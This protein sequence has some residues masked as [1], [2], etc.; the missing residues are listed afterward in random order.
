M[1]IT[2]NNHLSIFDMI[3]LCLKMEK[4][5]NNLSKNNALKTKENKLKINFIFDKHYIFYFF[6]KK[7]I[8]NECCY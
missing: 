6:S 7:L 4:S 1:C 8:L 2:A 5:N 3:F